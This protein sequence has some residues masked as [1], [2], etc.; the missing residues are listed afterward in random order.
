MGDLSAKRHNAPVTGIVAPAFEFQHVR[1]TVYVRN[2]GLH[3]GLPLLE[4]GLALRIRGRDLCVPVHE[5]PAI[6]VCD[7]ASS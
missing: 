2:L 1:R 7:T 3:A 5:S 4:H 6:P